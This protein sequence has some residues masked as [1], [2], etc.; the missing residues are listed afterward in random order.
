MPDIRVRGIPEAQV[1]DLK[2]SAA[3]NGRSLEAEIRY[4]L[5][6]SARFHNA[7]HATPFDWLRFG[8]DDALELVPGYQ[9]L[10]YGRGHPYRVSL[11]R[12]MYGETPLWS[13]EIDEMKQINGSSVW[14]RATDDNEDDLRAETPSGALREC[15]KWLSDRAGTRKV[16]HLRAQAERYRALPT[17]YKQLVNRL[18]QQIPGQRDVRE[19]TVVI[20]TTEKHEIY[21]NLIDHAQGA[22]MVYPRGEGWSITNGRPF[23]FALTSKAATK[24]VEELRRLKV[25]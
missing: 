21:V 13:T 19:R 4:R 16:A 1:D 18:T 15:M 25:L 22:V 3:R 12:A 23:Y 7:E 24:I 2:R 8:F 10:V 9:Y 17:E 14:T 11:R 6:E 5:E 20:W